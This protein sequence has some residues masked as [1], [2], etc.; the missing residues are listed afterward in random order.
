MDGVG[1]VLARAAAKR[2]GPLRPNG[3][4]TSSSWKKSRV[5]RPPTVVLSETSAY[6]AAGHE[7]VAFSHEL[8]CTWG[9]M[10]YNKL[11]CS[12]MKSI[13]SVGRDP[14]R[15]ENKRGAVSTKRSR[16]QEGAT[17]ACR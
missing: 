11:P 14:P 17:S 12:L 3:K 9:H 10:R 7:G 16:S 2:G 15:C 6:A 1:G 4:R 13:A 8:P 5:R